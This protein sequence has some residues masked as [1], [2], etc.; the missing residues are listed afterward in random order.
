VTNLSRVRERL[1]AREAALSPHAAREVT[2][3][4]RPRPEPPALV[5]TA[6][7]R[8]RDR[9][10]HSKAFRRLKHK[11]QVFI[12]PA[13]DHYVTR[14]THTLEVAQIARTITRALNL[15][16]DLAEA[17]ALGHDIGHAPFGHTG[18]EELAA[19]L[20]ESFRHNY[21]SVRVL[22]L[23]ENGGQGLNL[24]WEVTDA[25]EKSSKT[26][27]DILSFGWGIP[28]TLE[29]RV[30]KLSDAI[31]YINHDI[32]DAVRADVIEESDLPATVRAAL[33]ATHAQR[34]DALVSDVIE[35]SWPATG[36]DGSEPDIR[37][38]EGMHGVANVL[39][40]FMFERVYLYEDRQRDAARGSAIVRFL[41]DHYRLHPGEIQSDFVLK[42][43]APE[44]QA[45]DFVA[46]MTDRYAITR[47]AA[48]G[49]PEAIEWMD[50]A[51]P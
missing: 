41:F 36:E 4:G 33:G 14:L 30:V 28:A 23:L 1:L 11:T 9:I 50:R 34:I 49:C 10:L 40:E 27:D 37:L 32:L 39:R 48:L 8:D 29:G 6:Y 25:I 12:A 7:Q 26:R 13:G 44:R 19:L 3:R 21:Q 15:N 45:A 47:A 22:Q 42:D 43:D 5:R 51:W 31:A 2:S 16:E 20:P 46:G 35:A 17:A 18:E 38:S 24:T